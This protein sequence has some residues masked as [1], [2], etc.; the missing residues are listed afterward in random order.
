MKRG[1]I[2]LTVMTFSLTA[3]TWAAGP[4][5]L[6]ID[7][8]TWMQDTGVVH[9]GEPLEEQPQD[10][11]TEPATGAESG[12]VLKNGYAACSNSDD[13]YPFDISSHTAG[14]AIAMP[15]ATSYPY[16]ATMDGSGAEVWIADA[17]DNSIV[18]IDVETD[19]VGHTIP[20]GDYPV[21]VAFSQ[22][23]SFALVACRDDTGGVDNMY[24]VSTSTHAVVGSW[25]GPLT[26]SGPGN[27]TLDGVSGKFYMVQWYD[28]DLHEIAADGT[29]VLRTA[30]VGDSLWQ[31]VA[32]PDGTV[33]YVTDRGSDEVRVIDRVTLTQVRTVSVGDDPWGIDITPDGAKLYVACE[34]SND[35]WVIDTTSWATTRIDVSP[36]DPRDVAIT[37]DGAT[38][39]VAGGDSGSPDLV[40]V[41]DVA[42]DT[43]L[44]PVS[45]PAGASNTNVVAVPR[46]AEG[47]FADDFE[48]GDFSAWSGH[49]P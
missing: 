35:V 49:M 45:L 43:L 44:T 39:F 13:A 34:D 36:G 10:G 12:R 11:V 1:F 38:A 46:V 31:L 14:P 15:G 6:W 16:D 26:F 28:G 17:S 30:A 18:V 42:T 3:P 32:D 21:S 5:G 8:L 40:Y 29:S 33:I 20:V 27:V 25:I 22:D 19:A 47:I 23:G 2:L 37:A 24:R 4:E 41:I 48:S 7:D 9:L